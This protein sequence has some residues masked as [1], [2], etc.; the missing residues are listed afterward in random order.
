[1]GVQ[2]DLGD[3]MER[4]HTELLRHLYNISDALDKILE[5]LRR[6]RRA[7]TSENEES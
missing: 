1:M 6:T 2:R 7:R 3:A 4:R 5:E